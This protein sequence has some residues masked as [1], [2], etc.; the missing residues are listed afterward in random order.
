VERVVLD[1]T[2]MPGDYTLEISAWNVPLS[3]QP[4]ALVV[5]VF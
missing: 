5:Q 3:P 4:F 1:M 2:E